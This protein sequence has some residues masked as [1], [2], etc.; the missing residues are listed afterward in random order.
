MVSLYY[1]SHFCS[2]LF[3][4]YP[5]FV[6]LFL[7]CYNRDRCWLF[8]GILTTPLKLKS[9]WTG[10]L[11]CPWHTRYAVQCQHPLSEWTSVLQHC[12]LPI[13]IWS[14]SMSDVPIHIVLHSLYNT[15]CMVCITSGKLC[16]ILLPPPPPSLNI[17]LVNP[18]QNAAPYRGR[19]VAS[20][21]P[22]DKLPAGMDRH[23]LA[24]LQPHWVAAPMTP[25]GE[26]PDMCIGW[27]YFLAA[28]LRWYWITGKL[29]TRVARFVYRPGHMSPGSYKISPGHLTPGSHKI[30]PGH[31]T[32]GSRKI[33]PGH[34]TPESHKISP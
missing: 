28:A 14:T 3:L 20:T 7:F 26:T 25:A 22:T 9:K 17:N 19:E 11:K 21:C 27:R 23:Q 29:A 32:P 6:C 31:L 16:V 24:R 34:L 8:S 30:S 33:S 15:L 5:L 18:G 12:A 2:C 1:N 10:S 13:A 4:F